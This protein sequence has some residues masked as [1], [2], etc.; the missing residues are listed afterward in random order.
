MADEADKKD[1][2]GSKDAAAIAGVDPW[3]T[4][5]AVLRRIVFGEEE[6]L[7]EKRMQM[8]RWGKRLEPVVL[9]AF[10]EETGLKL[11]RPGLVMHPT[12][13]FIGDTVDAMA[14][15]GACVEAKT[16]LPFA[17]AAKKWGPEN[18]DEAP[19]NYWVQ[20][21]HHMM[22]HNA[23]RCYIPVLFGTHRFEIR[24]VQRDDAFIVQLLAL[25]VEFWRS[26]V[27]PLLQQVKSKGV[28]A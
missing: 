16:C 19:Q 7:D 20:C 9:S 3:R 18:S 13:A 4:E 22:I 28:A 25:E 2:I 17:N 8:F 1:Y 23:P 21:Q 6:P 27:E 5:D 15:D 11:S 14:S 24:T 10:A 26:K 12:H